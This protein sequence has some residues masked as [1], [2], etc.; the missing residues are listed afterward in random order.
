MRIA[1]R[2]GRWTRFGTIGIAVTAFAAFTA[3]QV[4]ATGPA[5]QG[6]GLIR[7]DPGAFQ[8]YTLLSPL[9]SQT[10]FLIDMNGKVVHSWD[11]G[12]T[13]SSIAYLLENG[14]LL[15][16][17]ALTPSPFGQGVA[18][19]GGHVQE[20]TWDGQ[21]AWDFTYASATSIPHHDLVRLPNGNV[22]LIVED[23]KTADEA[24]AAGRIPSSVEGTEV[25]P[26][27]LV[28]IKPTGKTTGEVVWQ[29]HL[30]D[31]LIQDHDKARANFGDVAAHPELVD[32]NF[33]VVPDR[34]A[35][36]D[37]THFNAVAYNAKLDQVIVSLRNF[38]EIWILDHSTTTAEAATHRGGKY[39]N[40]GDLLYRWGNPTA[41]RAGTAADRRLFGQHNVHWIPDGLTGAGHLLVFNNGDGRPDG[42]YSTVDEIALPGDAS[43]RYPLTPGGTYGPERAVWSY[44]APN[45]T[46][47]YSFNISGATRLPNGNTL[48]CAGAPGIVFEITP[49]NAVVWQYNLPSFPAGRGAGAGAR[50]GGPNGAGAG[51]PGGAGA[52]AG[53]PGAPGARGAAAGAAPGR[54]PAAG[55]GGP[56]GGANAGKN[57]FR[58]YRYAAGYPGLA[59]KPLTPGKSLEELVPKA[60]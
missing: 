55:R 48:I 52:G 35:N 31:H 43:G 12:S 40:G 7:N 56:G 58:A 33:T 1:S 22:L 20:F 34:R 2:F 28:E 49:Q 8:G 39:G 38:S 44:S 25:R 14:N 13:P 42:M 54:G 32:L 45:K 10:T 24:I 53:R 6:T 26:D 27:S 50:P 16:A 9:S 15:R 46:D 37:W 51:R 3:A 59:G 19:A 18:G 17:G 57:V 21:L 30:W 41:Y 5:T 36:A 4:P 29:W 23:R 60:P 11:T 47:F